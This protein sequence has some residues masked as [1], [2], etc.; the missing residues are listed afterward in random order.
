MVVCHGLFSM[1]SGH[2]LDG[3]ARFVVVSIGRTETRKMTTSCHYTFTGSL[4]WVTF[5]TSNG[6]LIGGS[7]LGSIPSYKE[8]PMKALV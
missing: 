2:Q 7:Q 8:D 6:F 3:V 1:T 5:P 4:F